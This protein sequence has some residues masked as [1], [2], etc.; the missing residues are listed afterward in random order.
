[1]KRFLIVDDDKGIR[2]LMTLLVDR[3]YKSS[4]IECASNGKDAVDMAVNGDFDLII[5]DI[6]MPFMDG[7]EFHSSLKALDR[8]KAERMLLVSGNVYRDHLKY[9]QEE[10]LKYMEKPFRPGEFYSVVDSMLENI[11]NN[12]ATGSKRMYERLEARAKCLIKANCPERGDALTIDAETID[13]SEGGLGLVY[14]G[15]E[16][17]ANTMVNVFIDKMNIANRSARVIWTSISEELHFKAGLQW[18]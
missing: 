3:R 6:D 2:N 7:I 15:E 1:M 5:S 9:I 18:V 13:Y 8:N 12:E 16:L 11:I 17:P 14:K 10:G 4:Q